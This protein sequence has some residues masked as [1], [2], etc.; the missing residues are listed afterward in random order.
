MKT[1]LAKKSGTTGVGIDLTQTERDPNNPSH[2][3]PVPLPGLP[4]EQL[5]LFLREMDRRPYTPPLWMRAPLPAPR[6]ESP[7]VEATDSDR[8][9]ND[10]RHWMPVPPPILA[11]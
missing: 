3:M 5:Q 6:P 11:A 8:D 9:P 1:L 4:I 2:W 7:Q 10:P